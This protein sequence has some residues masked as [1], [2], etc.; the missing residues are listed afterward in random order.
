[1]PLTPENEKVA[2]E[3][4]RAIADTIRECGDEGC[5]SGILYASLMQ[6]GCTFELY[7]KIIVAFKRE[8][9]VRE[10]ADVLYWVA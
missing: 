10:S 1:M 9:Y 6:F 8:G 4:L 2:K 5:P 7:C 3:V